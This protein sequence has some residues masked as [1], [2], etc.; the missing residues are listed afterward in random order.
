MTAIINGSS[1]SIT[2]SDGTTQATS[3]VVSG[4]V[5]STI[6]PTGSVIQVVQSVKT[7]ALVGVAGAQWADVPGQGGVGSFSAT[8][9]P[10]SASNKILVT[11]DLKMSGNAGNSVVRSRLLR[12]S[13]PIYIGDAAGSR[14]QSMGQF[15]IGAVADNVYYLAQVGGT[16][17]D[18]PATTSAITY[19][20]QYGSDGTFQFSYINRTQDDRNTT[21]FDSRI[22]ASITLME[23]VG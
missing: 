10:S 5:P 22:A 1:P 16:Y 20:V 7:D 18:S 4:K 19:K 6:M 14:P 12:N 9:T 11:V 3:A 13:T 15:Y 17:L 2:F 23:I 8:I 21:Y